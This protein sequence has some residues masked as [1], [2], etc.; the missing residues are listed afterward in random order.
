MSQRLLEISHRAR[1]K[2]N[3]NLFSPEAGIEGYRHFCFVFHLFYTGICSSH[4][5]FLH[6]LK[7]LAQK[8]K[9]KSAVKSLLDSFRDSE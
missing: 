9:C 5:L 8:Q 2:R 1:S 3:F 4:F 6:L 7:A